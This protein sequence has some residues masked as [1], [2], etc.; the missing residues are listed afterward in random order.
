MASVPC[1]YGCR[2]L[3]R[4]HAPLVPSHAEVLELQG[5]EG[6]SC[7]RRRLFLVRLLGLIFKHAME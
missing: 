7:F 3:T 5:T 2:E 4:G 6:T 1:N